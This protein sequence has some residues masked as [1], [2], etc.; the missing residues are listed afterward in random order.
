MLV[1][2]LSAMFCLLGSTIFHLYL[3]LSLKV[4]TILLRL[5]Y[6]GICILIFGSCFPPSFYG[7]YCQP[8]YYHLYISVI[9]ITSFTVFIVSMMDF[10]HTAKYRK[11]KSLMYG[12]LGIFAGFPIFHLVF[13]S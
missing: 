10:I 4:K 1:F 2:L 6:A 5:D 3:C 13:N 11:I 9:G 8:G 12:S 7:F